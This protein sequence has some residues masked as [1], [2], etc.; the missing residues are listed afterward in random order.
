[1]NGT[2]SGGEHVERVGKEYV[3]NDNFALDPPG[4][5]CAESSTFDISDILYCVNSKPI[6]FENIP[7]SGGMN[8]YKK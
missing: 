4:T 5:D 6:K 2:L 8:L 7:V 3:A 1:M